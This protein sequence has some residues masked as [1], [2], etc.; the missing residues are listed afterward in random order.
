MTFMT[1]SP[2]IFRRCKFRVIHLRLHMRHLNYEHFSCRGS[3]GSDYDDGSV[4]GK[5]VLKL[6]RKALHVSSE[7][8]QNW[9]TLKSIF[10]SL[11]LETAEILSDAEL[12]KQLNWFGESFK[13]YLCWA[14]NDRIK[15]QL[16]SSI[17][18]R[19]AAT[20]D[21][22]KERNAAISRRQI[23]HICMPI[24]FGSWLVEIIDVKLFAG[25][26]SGIQE[27]VIFVTRSF[28]VF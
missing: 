11:S 16:L 20:M 3:V 8:A 1:S 13:I 2:S 28:E 14:A 18:Q 15:S 25:H 22:T 9:H 4:C 7:L 5:H 17:R 21:K 26:L 24:R 6:I 10:S 19:S 27:F 23:T 12:S